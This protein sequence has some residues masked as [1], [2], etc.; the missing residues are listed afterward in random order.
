MFY[1]KNTGRA[2]GLFIFMC[3]V[4]ACFAVFCVYEFGSL[5][6]K[7]N[8]IN[9][10][11]Y[12]QAYGIP[13]GSA[14]TQEEA[15]K[16]YKE[17]QKEKI[18]AQKIL[19]SEW[20]AK[21]I[22]TIESKDKL[23]QEEVIAQVKTL[24]I[25]SNDRLDILKNVAIRVIEKGNAEALAMIINSVGS[26][27]VNCRVNSEF[28]EASINS[29]NAAPFEVLVAANCVNIQSSQARNKLS[30]QI[31]LLPEPQRAAFFNALSS[32]SAMQKSI[33][34]KMFEA[35]EQQVVVDYLSQSMINKDTTLNGKSLLVT[36][37]LE[38]KA[39]VTT[40]LLEMSAERKGEAPYYKNN[41]LLA[42]VKQKNLEIFK[43]LTSAYPQDLDDFDMIEK[44]FNAM[45]DDSLNDFTQVLI[46][47]NPRI[48]EMSHVKIRM[49]P[50]AVVNGDVAL[51]TY[52]LEQG[53][54]PNQISIRKTILALALE[55]E[56]ESSAEVVQVLRKHGAL[57]SVLDIARKKRGISADDVCKHAEQKV[58]DKEIF[59]TAL[60]LL[61]EN[62]KGEEVSEWSEAQ[63]CETGIVYCRDQGAGVDACMASISSCPSD[64]G[65]AVCCPS[66]I[67]EQ[68]FEGRCAGLGVIET[69]TWMNVF[70]SYYG[71]PVNFR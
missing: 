67:K 26:P 1:M 44:L 62:L 30:D 50:K 56:K 38:D 52:L 18:K 7:Q 16:V 14:S 33:L 36:S 31:L 42:A 9:Q 61:K 15:L 24:P 60:K 10:A 35:D 20:T 4:L 8:R 29:H 13:K 19:K 22:K 3:T 53:V 17:Q 32:S 40:T 68:Y 63:L 28:L 34:K 57:E 65:N 12:A 37:I 11:E 46:K 27:T 59:I 69:V 49:L 43:R 45:A 2:S 58:A 64:G 21:L 6:I 25:R 71:I 51:V 47:H 54:S 41:A 5:K 23:Q 48:L 39:L 66:E 70:S 55:Q